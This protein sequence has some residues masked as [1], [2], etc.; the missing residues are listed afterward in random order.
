[1]AFIAKTDYFGLAGSGLICVSNGDGNAASVAEAHDEDGTIVA[2][3]VYGETGAPTNSYVLS[4]DA[5]L[6]AKLGNVGSNDAVLNQLQITT[7]AGS[8]PTITASGEKVEANASN[9]CTYSIPSV[10]VSVKHHAQALFSAFTVGG[11]GCHL[12]SSTFTASAT[13]SKATKDGTCVAHD[14]TDAKIEAQAT[15]IQ[16]GTTAPTFTAGSGWT[17]TA[18][19]ACTNPDA[20]YPTW[21]ATATKYLTKDS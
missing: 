4:G 6:S 19:L 18:P 21:T 2:W 7:A 14:V 16:T 9:T 20:D 13:I 17:V 5:T 12:Q 15:I 8:P 1:M 10:T 3:T 11:E